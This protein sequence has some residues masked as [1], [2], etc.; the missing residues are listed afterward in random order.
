MRGPVSDVVK[1]TPRPAPM[2]TIH[3][4]WCPECG[5][6]LEGR[7]AWHYREGSLGDRC[8]TTGLIE[9]TYQLARAAVASGE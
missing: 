9:L 4:W 6:Q 3:Q 2:P 7:W 8:P 1:N 5:R